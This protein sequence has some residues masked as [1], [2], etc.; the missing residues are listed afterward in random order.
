VADA[1]KISNMTITAGPQRKIKAFICSFQN[2]GKL[3][4][5][6]NEKTLW[7]LHYDRH[8]GILESDNCKNQWN[9]QRFLVLYWSRMRYSGDIRVWAQSRVLP[10][11]IRIW[12]IKMA[13]DDA[14][15]KNYRSCW[16]HW[17][18]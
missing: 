9:P 14:K 7:I 6:W 16:C 13:S 8:E 18:I 1:I 17:W 2:T 3:V 11:Q 15:N 10:W 4:Y 12:M 5:T